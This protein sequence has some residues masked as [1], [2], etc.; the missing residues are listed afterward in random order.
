MLRSKAFWAFAAVLL[1]AGV[2][3][4]TLA[5]APPAS[6]PA[7]RRVAIITGGPGE[8]WSAAIA[9]ARAA[10][11]KRGIQLDVHSPSDAE[12]V[13]QQMKLLA[14]A[15][16]SQCDAIAISPIDPDR[17]AA[18]I[19]QVAGMKPLVTFDSDASESAR[20]GYVGTSNFSAGLVTGTLVKTA[21]PDGGKI[22]VFLANDTKENLVDRLA[23]LQT[24][25]RESPVPEESPIDPRYT[26]VGV[27]Q[28]DGDNELCAQQI[29]QA[30]Q[31]HED[32]ACVVTLNSRQGPVAIDTL[33]A[34]GKSDAVKHIAFDTPPETLAA[35]ES[36][37]VFAAVA[38]DPFTYGHEA[39]LMLD[40]LCRGDQQSLPVVGRAAIHISVEP[41]TKD[42]V[43]AYRERLAARAGAAAE[44]P[45]GG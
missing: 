35:V 4:R 40:A 17:Q 18:Q 45:A 43:A 22:A 28:D 14:V 38:Q 7:P 6:R 42:N 15:G 9:G 27:F 11:S 8:Y 25:L 13:E 21:I 29:E 36:G 31:D 23:G 32:L 33:I 34:T 30:L 1:L 20:L 44:P 5:T 3:Y 37:A 41:V 2:A 39:V 26:V 16:G 24:R 19:T 10:A 12:N